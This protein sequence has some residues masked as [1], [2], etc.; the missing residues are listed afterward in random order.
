MPIPIP[1]IIHY[2]PDKVLR[3]RVIK[4]LRHLIGCGQVV[5]FSQGQFLPLSTAEVT[6]TNFNTIHNCIDFMEPSSLWTKIRQ[7]TLI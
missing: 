1:Y 7:R 3:I 4:L 6:H 2:Y 5:R